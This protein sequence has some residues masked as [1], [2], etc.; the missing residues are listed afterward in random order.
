[1]VA[2]F[3]AG[4]KLQAVDMV[5]RKLW[6]V[7]ATSASSAIP[8]ST[9]QVISNIGT[10][11]SATYR[12]GR[13]YLLTARFRMSAGTASSDMRFQIRDTNVSGTVRMAN[14]SFRAQTTGEGYQAL[15]EHFVANTGPSDITGRVLALTGTPGAGAT[16]TVLAS[17]THNAYWS[18][19]EMGSSDDYPEAIAL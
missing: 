8:A 1:M 6:T 17:S 18:C 13:A 7:T 9:E 16:L 14:A 3:I 11:P 12:A 19:I 2:T 4:V 15:I 5:P 10:S